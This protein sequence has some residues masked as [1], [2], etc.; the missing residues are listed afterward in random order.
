MS[1][2]D[3]ILPDDGPRFR[4]PGEADSL[5]LRAAHGCP[6]NRCTFCG[7][8][9][10]IPYRAVPEAE[11]AAAAARAARQWPDVTRIFLADGDV[12]GL[13]ASRLAS[14]L[15]LLGDLFPA[16]TRVNLYANGSSILA[17]SREELA[18]LKSLK[19]HTLYLGLESG[20]E[21]VLRRVHKRET[22][23]EMADAG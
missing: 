23:A 16:L 20:D 3:W 11:F 7:M 15:R 8:Y 5:I 19:L 9:K 10:D 12:M 13:P 18:E 17:K 22:A 4:P 14:M 6:W 21:T 2:L 1:L